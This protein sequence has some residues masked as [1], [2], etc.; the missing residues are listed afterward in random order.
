MMYCSK[1]NQIMVQQ[2]SF[3]SSSLWI[4]QQ[5]CACCE[6]KLPQRIFFDDVAMRHVVKSPLRI[7]VVWLKYG[8]KL[9]TRAFFQQMIDLKRFSGWWFGTFVIFRGVETTNQFFH[10]VLYLAT[11]QMHPIVW[12]LRLWLTRFLVFR[13]SLSLSMDC[14]PIAGCIELLLVH[15]FKSKKAWYNWH[16][17]SIVLSTTLYRFGPFWRCNVHEAHKFWDWGS[18]SPLEALK[19]D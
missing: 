18:V 15:C 16:L 1:P 13:P 12:S 10:Q 6:A 5:S 9:I 17:Q 3:S 8:L 14:L 7:A 11:N 4:L 19:I 2:F